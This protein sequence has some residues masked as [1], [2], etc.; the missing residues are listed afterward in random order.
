M[1]PKEY[2]YIYICMYVFIYIYVIFEIVHIRRKGWQRPGSAARAETATMYT[3]TT[4]KN[5]HD[6]EFRIFSVIHVFFMFSR[7]SNGMRGWQKS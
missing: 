3:H 6:R 2:V 7:C 5:P 4:L 1:N